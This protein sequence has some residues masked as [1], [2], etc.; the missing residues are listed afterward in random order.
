MAESLLQRYRPEL[1]IKNLSRL[2]Y[3]LGVL[4]LL[5]TLYEF[6]AVRSFLAAA[7]TADGS[8]HPLEV[9]SLEGRKQS[10]VSFTPQGKPRLHVVLPGRIKPGARVKV[11]YDPQSPTTLYL[12]GE[13][14]TAYWTAR[15]LLAGLFFLAAGFGLGVLAKKFGKPS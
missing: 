11:Y 12:E 8:I 14:R 15:F 3:V 1:S 2:A 7:E 5:A 9:V 4:L 13:S 10:I 6:M